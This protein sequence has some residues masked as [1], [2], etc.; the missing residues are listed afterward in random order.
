M[1][2]YVLEE[3]KKGKWYRVGNIIDTNTKVG[4]VVL[5]TA[6]AILKRTTA[7]TKKNNRV[8]KLGK[9]GR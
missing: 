5:K 1:V 8:R 2:R 7:K 3:K 9:R 4:R 6:R